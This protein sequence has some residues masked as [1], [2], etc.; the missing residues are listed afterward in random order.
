MDRLRTPVAVVSVL[1]F[2]A[3]CNGQSK[4]DRLPAR[5]RT[6]AAVP[7]YGPYGTAKAASTET[8]AV[9]VSRLRKLGTDDPRLRLLQDTVDQIGTNTVLIKVERF[10]APVDYS[11][12]I[13]LRH[14]NGR[15][16]LADTFITIS[17]PNGGLAAWTPTDHAKVDDLLALLPTL[18]SKKSSATP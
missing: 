12:S 7:T 4:P 2:V 5:A 11:N 14:D 17:D 10:S 13:S 9:P 16:S 18:G 1:M 15:A 8:W 3:G 6:T